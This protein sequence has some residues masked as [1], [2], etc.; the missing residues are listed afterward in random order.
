M[1]CK[2]LVERHSLSTHH[3]GGAA[4]DKRSRFA[5][6]RAGESLYDFVEAMRLTVASLG[7]RDTTC[8]MVGGITALVVGAEV[9]PDE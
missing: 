9:V 2:R 5:L 6:W 3:Y 7:D 8:A 1:E 4:K